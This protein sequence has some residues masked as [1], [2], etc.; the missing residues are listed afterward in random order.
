M[1]STTHIRFTWCS[2]SQ[3]IPYLLFLVPADSFL[4]SQ[5]LTFGNYSEE[6]Q[7]YLHSDVRLNKDYF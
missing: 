5:Y 7:L 6:I 4:Y 1:L 2:A 3:G